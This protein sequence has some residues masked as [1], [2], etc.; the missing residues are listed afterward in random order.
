M[1]R[2]DLELAAEAHS[3]IAIVRAGEM[4]RISGGAAVQAE[5]TRPRLEALYELAFIRIFAAWEQ[6][7]ESVFYR[8]LCGFASAAA[9][10]E[11]LVTGSYYRSIGDAETAVLQGRDFLLW[12]NPTQVVKRCRDYIRHGHG[13]AC[14]QAAVISSNLAHLTELSYIR[15]R[16]AHRHQEDAKTKFDAATLAIAGR[17]YPSSRPGKFLRDQDMSTTPRLNWLNILSNELINLA[18]QFV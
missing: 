10:Q 13:F 18:A 12:H 17:T 14:I 3:A 11:Q 4:S 6:C 7:L 15:H 2:F 8:S 1:P 5:W 16:V 9:G